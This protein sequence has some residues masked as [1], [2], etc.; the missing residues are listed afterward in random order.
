MLT[1]YLDTAALS[2]LIERKTEPEAEAVRDLLRLGREGAVQLLHSDVVDSWLWGAR[3]GGRKMAIQPELDAAQAVDTLSNLPLTKFSAAALQKL[4]GE[5]R[6]TL[7]PRVTQAYAK[8]FYQ[9]SAPP[10]WP[11]RML[12]AGNVSC[13]QPW[14]TWAGRRR[15]CPSKWWRR[16][17]QSPWLSNHSVAPRA[18]ASAAAVRTLVRFH[19]R[20]RTQLARKQEEG[21]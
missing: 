14:S 17:G 20:W 12:S 8:W 19:K 15:G 21:A 9:R 2:L 6:G 13:W 16:A 3:A 4:T 7:Y 11:R 10:C 1:I 18:A 5:Q